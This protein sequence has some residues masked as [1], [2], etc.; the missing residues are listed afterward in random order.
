MTTLQIVDPFV[1]PELRVFQA[2]AEDQEQVQELILQTARWLHSRGSTQ[3]GNLLQGKDDHNLGGA[4]AR[5]EVIT[6]RT[7]EDH[8]LAGAVILQQQPSAWDRKLWG[9]DDADSDGG[10]SVYLHRLVVDRDRTGK[11]LGR[12]LVQWIEKGIRF[13]GKD[14]IR[15]DCIAGNDKLN[16]FYQQCG[17]TYIG[18]TGGYN[19][20]EKML[21]E[22][23]E[24]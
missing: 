12:E 24:K 16:Q 9:L 4:I 23:K 1:N 3:W 13:T 21:T 19:I 10:T 14:R 5:G 17:Y 7:S 11:G 2:G 18:E 15:L 20:F 6:F 8:A 22:V